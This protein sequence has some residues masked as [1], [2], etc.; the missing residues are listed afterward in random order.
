M[1]IIAAMI[2]EQNVL[3][4]KG[5]ER[6]LIHCICVTPDLRRMNIG[7]VLMK[8]VMNLRDYHNKKFMA[9]TSLPSSYRVDGS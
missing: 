4:T 9:I 7:T 5:N 3:M 6:A 1:E 8:T 2:V